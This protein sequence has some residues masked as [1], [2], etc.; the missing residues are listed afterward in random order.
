MAKNERGAIVTGASRG[1]GR[2]IAVRMAAE[3]IDVAI[4]GRP[5]EARSTTLEGSLEETALLA[6]KTARG[7]RVHVVEADIGAR[8]TDRA[9]I[10]ADVAK[11][12]GRSPDIL[13]HSAA[14]PREFGDGKPHVPFETIDANWFYRSVGLNV[15]AYWDLARHMIPGMRANGRGWLLAISSIQ[16]APRPSPAPDRPLSMLGGAP[17]YGGTKAFLDRITTG[18]AEELYADHIAVNALSPTG[19]VRTPVSARVVPNMPEDAWE[20]METMVE[21]ALALCTSE[22]HSLTSR[23]AYSLPLLVELGRTVRTLDGR[24]VFEDWQPERDGDRVPEVAYLQGH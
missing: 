19:P 1:I 16:A 3:G 18:A 13:V 11:H 6:R 10:V 22:P 14:A 15:W 12:F 4:V 7:A 23:I 2:A 24:A 21:A 17:L 8:T 9:A 20:P 5:A